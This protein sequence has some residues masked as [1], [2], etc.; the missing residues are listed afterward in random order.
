LD[1]YYETEDGLST[2]AMRFDLWRHLPTETVFCRSACRTASSGQYLSELTA[3]IAKA[4]M[5]AENKSY[6][7]KV[8][9]NQQLSLFLKFKV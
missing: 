9:E 2:I 5:G 8:I 1:H 3:L 4:A 6:A 7:T